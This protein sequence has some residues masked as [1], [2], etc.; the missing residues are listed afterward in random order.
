MEDAAH[1]M[2]RRR[3]HRGTGSGNT[4]VSTSSNGPLTPRTASP[5][6]TLPWHRHDDR[7]VLRLPGVHPA[8]SSSSAAAAAAA[9]A[10]QSR[11][12][13]TLLPHPNRQLVLTQPGPDRQLVGGYILE[14]WQ[15][16]S[17]ETDFHNSIHELV[18]TILQRPVDIDVHGSSFASAPN[19]IY[20]LFRVYSSKSIKHFGT[21]DARGRRRPVH[22]SAF[23]RMLRQTYST[24][25]A[26]PVPDANSDPNSNTTASTLRNRL[27][28]PDLVM[29]A[30]SMP[31]ATYASHRR[32]MARNAR[33]Q[34]RKIETSAAGATAAL[35]AR[36]PS[37]TSSILDSDSR[38]QSSSQPLSSSKKRKWAEEVEGHLKEFFAIVGLVCEMKTQSYF[39]G[40]CQLL[41][42]LWQLYDVCGTVLGLVINQDRYARVVVLPPTT[43]QDQ[44][45]ELVAD[46]HERG[47][48]VAIE[49]GKSEWWGRTATME[50]LDASM[51]RDSI[52]IPNQICDDKSLQLDW[53]NIA[54]LIRYI[55]LARDVLKVIPLDGIRTEEAREHGH[56]L[57]TQALR[58]LSEARSA[59]VGEG[60]ADVVQREPS[61]E[62]EPSA[63]RDESRL[64]AALAG[65]TNGAS[66]YLDLGKPSITSGAVDQGNAN[67]ALVAPTT[68]ASTTPG[69][70]GAQRSVDLIARAVR[71]LNHVPLPRHVALLQTTAEGTLNEGDDDSQ[72][73]SSGGQGPGGGG[74]GPGPGPGDAGGEGGG[75]GEDKGGRSRDGGPPAPGRG[76]DSGDAGDG[77]SSNSLGSGSLQ[78]TRAN[79]AAHDASQ[80]PPLP[81]NL[82][83][84]R[85]LLSTDSDVDTDMEDDAGTNAG[86]EELRRVLVMLGIRVVFV[87]PGEMD[88]MIERIGEAITPR[89]GTAASEKA[90]STSGLAS[91]NVAA[92]PAVAQTRSVDPAVIVDA[93]GSGAAH[94]DDAVNGPAKVPVHH[95]TG[96]HG[97]WLGFTS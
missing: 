9:A 26:P 32:R 57:S 33:R 50:E 96:L 14:W 89:V 27:D 80:I 7:V 75:G 36:L 19:G 58:A 91:A 52:W 61:A 23:A 44:D 53:P 38:A 74:S 49:T 35:L 70:V 43:E 4:A 86:T 8:S 16:R 59:A 79:L 34:A 93:D 6:L 51:Y 65:Q 82:C 25:D 67:N 63:A 94:V 78:L 60:A 31:P 72:P 95:L 15:D 84:H 10:A 11:T 55:E 76:G 62:V 30:S 5:L 22:Q 85:S 87:S 2:A 48:R 68:A 3:A 40:T 73:T 29:T 81:K 18:R 90:T 41:G 17:S 42:Y 97:S 66:F 39:K 21:T 24:R 54:R 37:P 83:R 13:S 47:F 71:G 56:A 92:A 77:G 46:E 45:P 69:T 28:A 64:L 20:P 1:D 12:F 88:G